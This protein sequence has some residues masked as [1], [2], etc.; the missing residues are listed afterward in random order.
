MSQTVFSPVTLLRHRMSDLPSP[1]RSP[2]PAML[3]L[4]S[5]TVANTAPFESR[6]APLMSQTIF[7]PVT[8]LCHRTSDLPSAS[9]SPTPAMLQLRSVIAFM[10]A[11]LEITAPMDAPLE[12]A[13]PFMSQIVFSPVA[14]WRH[15]M[16]DLPSPLKSPTPAMLQ[17]GS[18]TVANIAALAIAAPFM[19]QI[20]FSPVARLRHRIS[21]LPSPLKS[22]TPAMLQLISA[23]VANVTML[24]A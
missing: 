6:V 19:S 5:A 1:S 8:L 24:E 18:D 21:D 20:T 13:V 15:R 17:L 2:T 22:P 16:S 14:R 9:K 4:R 12:I 23:T 10:P 7:S 11:A 3:Q